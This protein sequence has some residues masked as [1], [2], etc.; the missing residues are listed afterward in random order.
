[1][2]ALVGTLKFEM[3]R[4]SATVYVSRNAANFNN[5]EEGEHKCHV[6]GLFQVAQDE[7]VQPYFICEL[8]SGQCIYAD[9]VHVRFTDTVEGEIVE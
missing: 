4:R 1:M 7:D 3:P 6:L 5:I 9:P 8:N 2:T